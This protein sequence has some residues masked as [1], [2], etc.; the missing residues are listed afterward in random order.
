M[1]KYLKIKL[2]AESE[3]IDNPN[4][5]DCL[6]PEEMVSTQF[7]LDALGVD[8]DRCGIKEN[9]KAV[10]RYF[11]D[12]NLD[13]DTRA[14][15]E[16]MKTEALRMLKEEQGDHFDLYIA[17]AKKAFDGVKLSDFMFEAIAINEA[18]YE[19]QYEGQQGDFRVATIALNEN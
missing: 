18:Q 10:I 11:T 15:I 6:T 17:P 14:E 9:N 12:V 13:T 19:G 1:L 7:V 4:Y 5:L 3:P 2:T 16:K 8:Y